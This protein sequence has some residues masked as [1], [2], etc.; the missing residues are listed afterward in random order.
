MKK[1]LSLC[2]AIITLISCVY[3]VNA[4]ES[5]VSA[6]APDFSYKLIDGE[7]W[8][9]NYTGTAT[10]LTLPTTL[11]GYSVVGVS[12]MDFCNNKTV[13]SLT[14]PGNIKTV[15]QM[16]MSNWSALEKVVFEEGVETIGWESFYYCKSLSEVD[17]PDSLK[18]IDAFAFQQ[19][20]IY[21]AAWKEAMALEKESG[22]SP[23]KGIYIDK[24]LITYAGYDDIDTINI[25]EGTVGLACGTFEGI[26]ANCPNVHVSSTVK[27]LDPNSLSD[28][29]IENIT[30]DENNPYYT[31]VDGILYDKAVERVIT[32]PRAKK[33]TVY[34]MPETV[35]A[36]E[37]RA[38]DRNIYIEKIIFSKNAEDVFAPGLCSGM[39]KIKAFEVEEGNKSFASLNGVLYSADY[40]TLVSYPSYKEEKSFRI[41]NGVTTI[42]NGAFCNNKN[43]KELFIADTVKNIED[44]AFSSTANIYTEEFSPLNTVL[45]SPENEAVKKYA[46][47][48]DLTVEET[49]M[50]NK[51]Y[52]DRQNGIIYVNAITV[53]SDVVVNHW[54]EKGIDAQITNKDGE[55]VDSAN[56]GT[57][58]IVTAGDTV[59]SVVMKGDVDGTGVV[60][61]TDYIRL[62]KVFLDE[63]PSPEGIYMYSAD[64]DRN[65]TIDSTDYLQIKK[66]F[67]GTYEY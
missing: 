27:Y 2:L 48:Y 24:W 26:A 33:D 25:E 59:Y 53:S 36:V 9:T 5:V 30:V 63:M 8:L 67:L 40:K 56:L 57:G 1:I 66:V 7:A 29:S 61:S 50:N 22:E 16:S 3:V 42:L 55:N 47:T 35:K 62:K 52:F 18:K 10:E 23:L 44:Y 51:V 37:T 41:P 32:Y 39:K 4:T 64:M 28:T 13:V 38:F 15:G 19:S 21:D 34:K 65:D 11:D 31:A 14:I 17:F 60:D 49:L 58:V 12:E 43:I 46:E 45:Y 54:G 20:A 6:E